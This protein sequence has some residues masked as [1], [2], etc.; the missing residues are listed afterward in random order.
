MSRKTLTILIDNKKS[1][2]EKNNKLILS[3]QADSQL[4]ENVYF[5]DIL[6]S[7]YLLSVNEIEAARFG[8]AAIAVHCK[9]T[10][11]RNQ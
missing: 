11:L 3:K 1:V 2:A 4:S 6:L 7:G 9:R 5:I 10:R 8:M